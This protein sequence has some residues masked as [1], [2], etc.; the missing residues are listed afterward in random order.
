MSFATIIVAVMQTEG[1]FVQTQLNSIPS[2]TEA[3]HII[4]ATRT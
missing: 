2:S 3:Y 4:V 1:T